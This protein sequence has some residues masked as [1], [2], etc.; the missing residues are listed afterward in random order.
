MIG[1]ALPAKTSFRL[2]LDVC[3]LNRPFNDQSQ[4]RIRLETEAIVIILRRAAKR[5]WI[6]VG[7]GVTDV[8]IDETPDPIRRNH[9]RFLLRWVREYIPVDEDAF[10]RSAELMRLGFKTM[11]AL[12]IACAELGQV[13]ALL[14]TDERFL[15]KA[16]REQS[17][18]H[19]SVMNPTRWVL[20]VLGR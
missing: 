17:K 13:D 15:R 10:T 11:D 16:V 2:Y 8:E 14:T 1:R 5:D 6:C 18:L 9:V 12:H 20:E 7:S 19:V 3:C 4:D